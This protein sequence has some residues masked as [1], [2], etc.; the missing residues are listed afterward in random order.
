MTVYREI[1][2]GK[3]QTTKVRGQNRI[4]KSEIERYLLNKATPEPLARSGRP[5]RDVNPPLKEST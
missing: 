5:N 2:R 3:L 1:Q 4:A